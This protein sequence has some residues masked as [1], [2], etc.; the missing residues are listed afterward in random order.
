M[1]AGLSVSTNKEGCDCCVVAIKGTFLIQNEGNLMLAD[2]QAPMVYADVHYGDPKS[3]CIR[4]ERDFA[5]FNP[6]ADNIV[7]G[8]AISPQRGMS[9]GA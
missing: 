5:P 4:Y 8:Y 3:T 6:C 7:N 9:A 2:E 1:E